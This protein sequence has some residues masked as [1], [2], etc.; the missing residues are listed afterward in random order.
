MSCEM[1]WSSRAR[2]NELESTRP[3]TLAIYIDGAE[4]IGGIAVAEKLNDLVG[5]S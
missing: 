5:G 2:P 4:S 1:T 3:R